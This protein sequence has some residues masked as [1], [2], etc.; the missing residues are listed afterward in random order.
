LFALKHK[1]EVIIGGSELFGE[2][3]NCLHPSIV[4]KVILKV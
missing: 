1:R 2:A 3:G 4:P